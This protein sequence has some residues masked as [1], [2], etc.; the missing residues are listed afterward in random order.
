ME[1]T[2]DFEAI[3]KVLEKILE[4]PI[5]FGDMV[6]EMTKTGRLWKSGGWSFVEMLAGQMNTHRETIGALILLLMS[7]AILS[8]VS[9]AFKSRQISDMGFYVIYL[10]LFLI[11]MKSFTACY[12]LTEQVIAD[13]IGFMKVLMPA[14]LMAVAAAAYRATAVVYYEAFFVM[15][16][17]IQKMVAAILL[18]AIRVYVIFTILGYLGETDFLG[19]SRNLLKRMILWSMKAMIAVTAGIQMIQGMLTPAVDKFKQTLFS[20]GI[21][22]LGS[23]GNVTKN[24]TD[25]ILGSGVLLKNGVGAAA[26]LLIVVI[27]LM[28]AIQVM[29][30][31]IFYQLLAAI[32][33]PVSDQRLTNMISNVGDGIGLLVKLLFTVCAMFLL[34]ISIVSVTTGGMR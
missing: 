31:M 8:T 6:A 28:P 16:Y 17:Y 25:V 12:A 24:V 22:G 19:K 26:A 1:K 5:G 29:S 15:I 33:E 4:R 9:K 27:C 10:L 3:E 20:R 30:Y 21:A 32:S 34:T 13:L 14:Y 2:A 7:A 18:P 23:V 11:M